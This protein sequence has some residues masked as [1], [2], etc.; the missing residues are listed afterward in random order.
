M[1]KS[2]KYNFLLVKSINLFWKNITGKSNEKHQKKMY[3]KTTKGD[4]PK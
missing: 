3:L 4:F 1:F 2:F